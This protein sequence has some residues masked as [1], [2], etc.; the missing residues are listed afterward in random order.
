M[1]DAQIAAL[2]VPAWK[3][4]ILTALAH[5]GGYVGDTGQV[6]PVRGPGAPEPE[7]VDHTLLIRDAL[8]HRFGTVGVVA[9][10]TFTT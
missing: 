4:T 6:L 9:V 1:S 10:S 8:E 3:K 5:Y 7:E 2:A